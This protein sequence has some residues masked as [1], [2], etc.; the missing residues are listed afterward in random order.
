MK[1]LFYSLATVSLLLSSCSND[2]NMEME[3]T[4]TPA[5]PEAKLI[6]TSNTTGKISYLDLLSAT[7]T[8]KPLSIQ[9]MDSDGSY[10]NSETDELIIASRTNNRLELYTGLKNAVATNMDNLMLKYSSTSDFNNA[11]EI[12]VIGDK[13]IVTQD[14]NAANG[15]VNKLL[16]YQKTASGFTLLNTYTPGFKVWGI[17]VEGTKLYAIVDL[18]SDLVVF[19]NFFSNP[20]GAITPTKR[21]TIQG[22]VRTHGI[23]YSSAKDRMILTD[24]GSA[25][26]DT[27]GGIVVINSFSVVIGVTPNNGTIAMSSQRRI[28][29][30]NSTLGNP[31]D[32]AYDNITDKIYVAER[33]NGGGKV[34]TFNLPTISGDATPINTRMEPGA[35]SVY[36][37]RK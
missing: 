4:P 13:V 15:N 26:S 25:T 27:D 37:L 11:R 5:A 10:Y 8:A 33:L 28:Y 1:K 18:T 24:V 22:L 32:C 35:T 23:T 6:T 17:H 12:A 29:G 30:T 20:N 16:V 19:D 14:Q 34:L 36:L 21:V 2:D 31:V 9:S 7:A 3:A